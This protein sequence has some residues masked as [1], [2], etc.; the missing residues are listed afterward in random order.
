M[1]KGAGAILP[2]TALVFV[3]FLGVAKITTVRLLDPAGRTATGA[4]A[5]GSAVRLT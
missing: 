4:L 5:A 1:P 3:S 2:G